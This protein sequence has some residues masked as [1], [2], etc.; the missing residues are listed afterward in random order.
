MSGEQWWTDGEIIP[1]ITFNLL[2]YLSFL[3]VNR[4]MKI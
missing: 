2:Y 1:V 3:M 4:G